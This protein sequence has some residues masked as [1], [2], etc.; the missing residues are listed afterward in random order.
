MANS[1][2]NECNA[3]SG[4]GEDGVDA[5]EGGLVQQRKGVGG[6]DNKETPRAGAEE[7]RLWAVKPRSLAGLL[8]LARV[9]PGRGGRLYGGQTQ[10]RRLCAARSLLAQAWLGAV[11][12]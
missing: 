1:W 6:G 12:S 2:A 9:Q 10:Q 3:V 4:G 7:Q 5:C 11:G 8:I